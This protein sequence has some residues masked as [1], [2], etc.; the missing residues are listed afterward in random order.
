M[1]SM[2]SSICLRTISPTAA[3]SRAACAFS[4][5]GLPSSLACT[6]ASSSTGRGRL[7]TWVVRM[8][9]VLRCMASSRFL[10]LNDCERGLHHVAHHRFAL[11]GR[12]LVEFRIH[13]ARDAFARQRLLEFLADRRV[14]LVIGDGAAAFAQ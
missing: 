11:A 8:R 13:P 12:T 7:P 1:T 9:S 10:V 14:F 5:M 6:S 4:S 2:P 3:E